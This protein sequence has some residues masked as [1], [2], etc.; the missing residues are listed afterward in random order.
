MFAQCCFNG[1]LF[2]SVVA[3]IQVRLSQE[4][5]YKIVPI[6]W[7]ASFR[8]KFEK[9]N[10][11]ESTDV[12][13]LIPEIVVGNPPIKSKEKSLFFTGKRLVEYIISISTDDCTPLSFHTVSF[14]M[15]NKTII[16][17]TNMFIGIRGTGDSEI[18][19]R[20]ST[21]GDMSV[22]FRHEYDGD[23][24]NVGSCEISGIIYLQNG[25]RELGF[26]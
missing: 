1:I 3:F 14:I 9:I 4:R 7:E 18:H 23:L 21:T 13:S 16:R 15:N 25:R 2:L 8:A 6:K 5:D 11:R 24:N 20:V 12:V 19:G 26:A 17:R 22:S 10:L